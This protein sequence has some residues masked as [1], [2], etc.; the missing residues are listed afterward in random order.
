MDFLTQDLC[1]VCLS[2]GRDFLV[3]LTTQFL[4]PPQPVTCCS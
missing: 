3:T 4:S 1:K 2:P